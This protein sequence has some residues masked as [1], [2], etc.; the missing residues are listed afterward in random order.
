MDGIFQPKP[1]LVLT[2][3]KRVREGLSFGKQT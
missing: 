3:G 2:E 1:G